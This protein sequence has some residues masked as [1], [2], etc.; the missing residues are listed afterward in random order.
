MSMIAELLD[1]AVSSNASDVHLKTDQVPYYRINSAL[2]ATGFE[3]LTQELLFQMVDDL[4]PAHLRKAFDRDHEIDFS[5]IEE[6]VGRFRVSAFLGAGIPAFAFRYVKEEVPTIEAL[7]LPKT[8]HR[9]ADLSSGLVV[10]SGTT[11]SGK[12]TTLAA[13][14]EEINLRHERRILTIEDTIEYAFKDKRSVITQREV[15]LDAEDFNSALRHVLRQDPDVILLGEMRDVESV[16]VGLLASETG[17]LVFT[18]LHAGTS[19]IAVP[20]MLDL[21][22]ASE[23]EQ[24]RMGLASSLR[25]IIC[26]RLLPSTGGGL[27]PAVE[28]LFNTPSVAKLLAKN[29]LPVLTAAMETG[30]EDGMQT[31]NQHLYTLIREGLVSEKEGLRHATNAESLSMNLKGIFL[32]EGR[33]I[34]ATVHH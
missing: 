29:Y 24:I 31:F 18:T 16:R 28:I 2:V 26:Q 3:P 19:A 9:L 5:H 17:H 20:R 11:G 30:T 25:A 21:F 10:L 33:K 7:N 23:Q 13:I 6:D 4:I 27:M 1:H 22:P 12:S 32:D 34:L 14:I 8:L 15:G